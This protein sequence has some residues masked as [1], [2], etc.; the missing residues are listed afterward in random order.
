MTFPRL[1]RPFSSRFR[2]VSRLSSP[3]LETRTCHA[4]ARESEDD[5]TVV[6]EDEAEALILRNA[7]IHGVSVFKHVLR[8]LKEHL[9]HACDLS[10][11]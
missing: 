7:A 8:P 10:R 11:S 2:V 6:L 1:F 4:G 3:I 5:A 9:K